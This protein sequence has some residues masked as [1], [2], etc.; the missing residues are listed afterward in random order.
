MESTAKFTTIHKLVNGVKY[1]LVNVKILN[2]FDD[3]YLKNLRIWQLHVEQGGG[4]TN[5]SIKISLSVEQL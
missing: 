3:I 4:S 2:S 5:L 1:F